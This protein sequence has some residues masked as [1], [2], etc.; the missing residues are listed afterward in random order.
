MISY[1]SHHDA[2]HAARQSTVPRVL[3]T[4]QAMRE[5]MSCGKSTGFDRIEKLRRALEAIDKQVFFNQICPAQKARTPGVASSGEV[6][7]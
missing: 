2:W 4:L 5:Q 1:Q 7:R 6:A 3:T